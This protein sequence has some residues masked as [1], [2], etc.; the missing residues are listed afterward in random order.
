LKS[1]KI[2]IKF[3]QQQKGLKASYTLLETELVQ[4]A[5]ICGVELMSFIVKSEKQV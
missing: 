4:A 5:K 3:I 1:N 2:K